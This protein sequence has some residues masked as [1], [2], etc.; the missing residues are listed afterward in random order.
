MERLNNYQI[1]G[2]CRTFHE[3]LCREKLDN[4][5]DEIITKY[6]LDTLLQTKNKGLIS[7]ILQYSIITNNKNILDYI[8]PL[9]SMKRDYFNIIIYNRDNKV[10]CDEIFKKYIPYDS[11]IA[12]DIEFMIENN[13][14][15][16]IKNLDGQFIK[17]DHVGLPVSKFNINFK[18]YNFNKSNIYYEDF[19]CKLDGRIISQFNK[20]IKNKNYEYIIDAGNILFSRNG[21]I[22]DKSIDDLNF[23][24][25]KNKNKNNLIII[26][27]KH[28]KNKKIKEILTNKLYFATPYNFN[29]DIFIIIAYLYNQCKIITNDNFKDHTIENNDF[30]N[31]IFDDLI[32]YTNKNNIISFD[33]ELTYNRCIQ[34]I[35]DKI[36]IPTNIGFIDIV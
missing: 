30:R 2:L 31:F 16:L 5:N 34:V 29:D 10:Y 12:K 18:K 24:I 3:Y 35:E 9:I 7:L 21:I 22:T 4:L 27:C 1:N 20:V 28:L 33:E 32:K 8:F 13:I 25:N 11:I 26:H 23:V 19:L 14:T 36:Y 15:Y 6:G 17:L